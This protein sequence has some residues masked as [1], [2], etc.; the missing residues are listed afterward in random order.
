MNSICI[1]YRWLFP[2]NNKYSAWNL[3]T[4]NSYWQKD[5]IL[6]N[7]ISIHNTAEFEGFFTL[8]LYLSESEEIYLQRCSLNKK[9]SE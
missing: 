9:K 4:F 2:Q 8:T 1:K 7:E 3:F 5:Y 6:Q